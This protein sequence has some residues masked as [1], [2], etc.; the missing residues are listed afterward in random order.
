MV[1]QG[2]NLEVCTADNERPIDL[3][4]P[5]DLDVVSYMLKMQ[6][7]SSRSGRQD[8][9][10][11]RS[12]ATGSSREAGRMQACD[13][14]KRCGSGNAKGNNRLKDEE[15][16]GKE[17]EGDF[18]KEDKRTNKAEET[19]QEACP[20]APSDEPDA[21]DSAPDRH[22]AGSRDAQPPVGTA[23]SPKQAPSADEDV[24]K[25]AVQQSLVKKS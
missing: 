15:A 7:S 11:R 17:G 1:E 21:R 10:S 6:M 25:P 12:E 4:D 8:S 13:D 2:A 22:L 24:S 18:E 23:P 19:H 20:S 9:H 5:A 14:V 16:E 3:V